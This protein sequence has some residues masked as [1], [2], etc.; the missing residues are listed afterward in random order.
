MHCKE[1]L[2]MIKPDESYRYPS[3][4]RSNYVT[5]VYIQEFYELTLLDDTKSVQEK[6]QE[7]IRIA[8][9]WEGSDGPMPLLNAVQAQANLVA[10]SSSLVVVPLPSVVVAPEV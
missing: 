7:T 4:L 5:P 8:S 10:P 3:A 9:K 1:I 2:V 6:T